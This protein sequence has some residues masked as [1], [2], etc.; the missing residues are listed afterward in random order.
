MLCG[1]V[2]LA[3]PQYTYDP[4]SGYIGNNIPFKSTS[5]NRRQNMYFPS[6]FNSPSAGLIT[7]IYFKGS[8]SVSSTYTNVIVYM[9]T[10]TASG[11]T[12][13]PFVTAGM[14]QTLNAPSFT[15]TSGTGNWVEFTLDTPFLW[16]ATS[17]LIIDVQ[18]AGYSVGFTAQFI[19]ASGRLSLYGASN[20]TSPSD[21]TRLPIF[22]YDMTPSGSLCTGLPQAGIALSDTSDVCAND[23]VYL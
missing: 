4:G 6:D 9:G 8:T 22:G 5:S 1:E 3:Q 23:T 21:Q 12:A 20:A 11:L 16:D 2:I 19:N 10:S 15:A 14:V 17:N 18:H 13:G 7:K